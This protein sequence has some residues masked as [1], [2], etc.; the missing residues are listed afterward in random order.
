MALLIQS[1]AG[2]QRGG[3]SA[4]KSL[5]LCV[6]LAAAAATLSAQN[7]PSPIVKDGIVAPVEEA[8][9]GAKVKG[10]IE[11][12]NVEEG[13]AV[14]QGQSLVELDHNIEE[15]EV[16]QR[17][18]VIRAAQLAAEKSRRDFENAKKLW[19]QN[20]ISEDE[21]R[22]ADLQHQIDSHQ[23]E[24]AEIQHRA[25][26][27]RLE[28]KFIRA[29]FD[30]IV[31]R[32]LKQRGEPVDELEKIVKIV[33]VARLNLVIYLDG[34]FMPRV[35]LGQ[36]AEIECTTMGKQVV[37]GKVAV[38]DPIVDAASGQFRLKIQFDNPDNAIK[39]GI[40][41]TATFLDEKAAASA[42]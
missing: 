33:N 26:R 27:Q 32:K 2:R 15:L 1:R 30:G 37:I 25:A 39:A 34:R 19:E 20:A 17:A 24:Q 42:R 23:A 28:D 11:Q 13:D 9:L 40:P 8:T 31:V 4:G 3:R 18:V 5:C 21:F 41:G 14:A 12:F 10:I 29:P 36:P 22:K 38:M 6:L 16:A 35:S 7:A